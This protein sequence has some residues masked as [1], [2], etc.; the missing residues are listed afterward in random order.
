MNVYYGVDL[1]CSYSELF[2]A[3][4][5]YGAR[6]TDAGVL[7]DYSYGILNPMFR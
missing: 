1:L 7:L 4:S 3:K 5:N 6:L 2:V